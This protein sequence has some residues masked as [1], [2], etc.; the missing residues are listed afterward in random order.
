MTTL[1]IIKGIIQH[2]YYCLCARI[3]ESEHKK[4]PLR[5]LKH[6][7]QLNAYSPENTNQQDFLLFLP[8]DPT[9][10]CEK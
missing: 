3:L 5:A 1:C 4:Q 8:Q 10:R 9:C 6:K 7:N 2:Y